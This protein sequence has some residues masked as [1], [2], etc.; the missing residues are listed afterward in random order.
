M[1][2][3]TILLFFLQKMKEIII[4]RKISQNLKRRKIKLQK[5]QRVNQRMTKIKIQMNV[6]V[7]MVFMTHMVKMLKDL[8]QDLIDKI[9]I[10]LQNLEKDETMSMIRVDKNLGETMS[11]EMEIIED[12]IGG[13]KG[14]IVIKDR[15]KIEGLKEID[16]I[17]KTGIDIGVMTIEIIKIEE[18]M[19]KEINVMKEEIMYLKI[20]VILKNMKKK[21]VIEVERKLI[22]IGKDVKIPEKTEIDQT[23]LEIINRMKEMIEE[24]KKILKE[25]IIKMRDVKEIIGIKEMKMRDLSESQEVDTMVVIVIKTKVETHMLTVK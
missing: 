10:H 7:T 20:D 1:V 16:R 22:Q 9:K 15:T 2:I 21:I 23:T 4:K 6:G 11:K 5:H 12:K 3:S 18:I 19:N 24:N 8:T 13:M 17:G 25:I 14:T